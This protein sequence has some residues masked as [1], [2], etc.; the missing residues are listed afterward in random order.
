M[1]LD[2]SLGHWEVDITLALSYLELAAQ[3]VGISTCWAGLLH[4]ALRSWQPLKDAVALPEGHNHQYGLMVGHAR[5][6]CFRL[7]ERKTPF[8]HWR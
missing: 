7:P 1:Y 8:I 4:G 6:K 2:L 5:P 3:T